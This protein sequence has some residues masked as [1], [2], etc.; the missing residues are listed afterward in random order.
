MFRLRL[1]R[2]RLSESLIHDSILKRTREGVGTTILVTHR[3]DL[4]REAPEI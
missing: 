2:S 3:I 1:Y 4:L